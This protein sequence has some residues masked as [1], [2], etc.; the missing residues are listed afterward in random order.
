MNVGEWV[1]YSQVALLVIFAVALLFGA[2][3]AWL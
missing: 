3:D 2:L 1:A